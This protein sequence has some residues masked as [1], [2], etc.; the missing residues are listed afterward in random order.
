VVCLLWPPTALT[1]PHTRRRRAPRI[2]TALK[3]A[4]G[5]GRGAT[6]QRA[7]PKRGGPHSPRVAVGHVPTSAPAALTPRSARL[8]RS[9]AWRSALDSASQWGRENSSRMSR[10][11]AGCSS[12]GG[13]RPPQAHGGES[14]FTHP[15]EAV[16]QHAPPPYSPG[17]SSSASRPSAWHPCRRQVLSRLFPAQEAQQR[18]GLAPA[19]D[20]VPLPLCPHAH[21]RGG[22]RGWERRGRREKGPPL[23]EARCA[24]GHV[25]GGKPGEGPPRKTSRCARAVR[26][27]TRLCVCVC[28]DLP[29]FPSAPQLCEAPVSRGVLPLALD[30]GTRG[31]TSPRPRTK[32]LRPKTWRR[33]SRARAHHGGPEPRCGRLSCCHSTHACA[34]AGQLCD[35]GHVALVGASPRG[36]SGGRC[37]RNNESSRDS[38]ALRPRHPGDGRHVCRW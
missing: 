8:R 6:A 25:W 1:G 2:V 22:G 37:G 14:H 35:V 5:A 4:P 13:P 11:S 3:Q 15:C 20:G 28:C 17:A 9:K 7:R 16:T 12:W 33:Q 26:R 21:V 23:G 18:R 10:S 19:V 32:A 31:L 27:R 30:T 29:H 36:W 34:W 24:S 38:P